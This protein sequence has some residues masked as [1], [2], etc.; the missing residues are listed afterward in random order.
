MSFRLSLLALVIL[1]GIGCE[2]Q[3]DE[4]TI[5][6]GHGLSV[7][8]PVHQAM[9][10]MNE[11]LVEKSDSTMRL[12]IY[13]NEQLGSERQ[14]LEM[15]QIGGLGMTKVSSAVL[16]GFSSP[17]KVFG[18]P[19]LFRSDEHR[20]AVMEGE[21]GRE[22]LLSSQDVWLRGLTFYDAGNRS[23]YTT[24]TA[25]RE[26]SDLQGLKVRTMNSPVSIRMVNAM[27]GSATPISFGE[28]Y[29]AL[30]QGVVDGAENNP[31]S[32]HLTNHYELCDY[33]ILD[34]HTAPQDVLLV[35]T[36]V[37]DRL[38][39]Q[40]RTWLQEAADESAK[41]QKKLWAQTTQESLQAVKDAGVEIIRPEKEPFVEAVQPV[42]EYYKEQEPRVYELSQKVQD[43]KAKE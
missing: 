34:E 4:V 1:F 17:Y 40:Q 26:P 43:L 6:L 39:S 14:L 35:S 16:E 21:I 37:W 19:Y 10:N 30:Q 11:R 28:L 12:E 13:P 23:F 33:Y 42:Y 8:H 18:L 9:Q 41:Y 7:S 27:G 5:R 29:T 3:Q 22:I 38:T 31:P 25:I 32:F 2:P 15:L 20:Y 24:D 36:H